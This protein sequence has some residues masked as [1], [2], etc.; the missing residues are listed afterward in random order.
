MVVVDKNILCVAYKTLMACITLYNIIPI[1][2]S[3]YEWM[4][5]MVIYLVCQ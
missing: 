5:F 1:M 4:F 3:L 2:L